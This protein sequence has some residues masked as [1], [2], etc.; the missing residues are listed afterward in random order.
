MGGEG[1]M[2]TLSDSFVQFQEVGSLDGCGQVLK[3]LACRTEELEL[4]L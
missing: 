3:G 1:P 4:V 2:R